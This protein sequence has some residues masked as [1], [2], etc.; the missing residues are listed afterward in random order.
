MTVARRLL[1]L[2]TVPLAALVGLGLFTGATSDAG[3]TTAR[4]RFDEDERELNRLLQDDGD[5]LVLG[6]TDRRLLA[7][8]AL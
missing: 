3:R 5:H 4:A 2:L 8:R 7:S 1:V 6:D